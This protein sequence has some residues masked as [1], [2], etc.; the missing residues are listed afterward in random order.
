MMMRVGTF[1][2]ALRSTPE[3]QQLTSSF[4][5]SP[6]KPPPAKQTIRAAQIQLLELLGA[7]PT[8]VE[9]QHPNSCWSAGVFHALQ[10]A[11]ADEDLLTSE[12][13]LK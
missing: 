10:T 3:F 4:G 1:L 11:T 12:Q 5:D 13:L 9:S 6:A 8:T 2:R 7:D